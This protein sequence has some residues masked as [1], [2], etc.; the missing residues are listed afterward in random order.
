M[1]TLTTPFNYTGGGIY[2]ALNWVAASTITNVVGSAS[3]YRDIS[4]SGNMGAYKASTTSGAALNTLQQ[5]SVRPVYIFEGQNASTNEASITGLTAPGIV[6]EAINAPHLIT[7]RVKNGSNTT[8]FNKQVFLN[9]T[10]AN[11]F[12]N[13]QV[14]PSFSA[15]ATATVVFAPYTPTALGMSTID[16]S[17]PNDNINSNNLMSWPQVVI[18]KVET[19]DGVTPGSQIICNG[20]SLSAWHPSVRKR[21]TACWRSNCCSS[22]VGA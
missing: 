7:A 2:V 20:S 14:I 4:S 9:V 19:G 3:Y 21:A 13:T 1:I 17:L 11:P 12:T 22:K 6:A 8:L 15:G 5:T 16:V 18:T 10:G